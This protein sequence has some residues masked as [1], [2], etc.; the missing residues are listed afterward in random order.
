VGSSKTQIGI[1]TAEC[2]GDS[3]VLPIAQ[4][5]PG[6]SRIIPNIPVSG[7]IFNDYY[8]AQGNDLSNG[9]VID[10]GF[11]V[12][13]DQFVTTDQKGEFRLDRGRSPAYWNL[14]YLMPWSCGW[15]N[16]IGLVEY[17]GTTWEEYEVHNELLNNL[18]SHPE[19]KQFNCAYYGALLPAS[20]RFAVLGN[21]PGTLTLG[22][23]IPFT[24]ANGMPLLYIYDK[25]SA[26]IATE[27]AT[28][29]SSDSTQATFPFPSALTEAGYSLAV[30]NQVGGTLQYQAAGTNLL[31][32]ASSQTIAGNP[33]GVAAAYLTDGFGSC[34]QDDNGQNHCSSGYST[35]SF[36]VVSLYSA[37]QVLVNGYAINVGANPTAVVTN[38]TGSMQVNDSNGGEDYYTGSTIAVVAN[39]G[40]NTI[41]VLDIVSN[42]KLYD[43]T[44]GNQPVALAMSSDGS[45]VYVA[46]YTDGTVTKVNLN[47][48]TV[49]GT[50]AVGGHPTS[51]A[52]TSTGV[53]WVGGVGFLSEINA[54]MSLVATESTGGKTISAL[55]YSNSVGELIATST[56]ASGNVNVEEVSPSSVQAGALYT[57]VSSHTVSALK[58]YYNPRAQAQVQSLTGTL[59]TSS[60]PINSNQQGAPPLVVQDGWAVVTATPTGFTITDITGHIVLVS[61]TTPSPISAIAVDKNLNVAYLTMPDSNIL[62]TVP[63]PGTGSN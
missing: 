37:N 50:V 3:T 54:Q 9:S 56:D 47:A 10:F 53:L 1:S 21:L 36:P 63:L 57:T 52:L 12:S 38:S 23:K 18:Y 30:V 2:Q 43:L 5:L 45:A 58:S 20:T 6:T 46:N 61:E 24:T 41:S 26:V 14:F 17:A 40:S 28:S 59:G 25:T 44:V 29:V 13:G 16:A 33:F 32:I 55:A 8:D 48:G 15:N 60:I 19:G 7:T 22:S 51:V 11:A 35:Y 34:E 27:T 49:S 4:C 39:S 62:L 31:S 42:A